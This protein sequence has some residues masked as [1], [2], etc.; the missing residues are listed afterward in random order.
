MCRTRHPECLTPLV[1]LLLVTCVA[2]S[3]M[4]WPA[5]LPDFKI[6]NS[7][8]QSVSSNTIAPGDRWLLIYIRPQCGPCRTVLNTLNQNVLPGVPG[9]SVIILGGASVDETRSMAAAFPDLPF[10]QWYSDPQRSAYL[11]LALQGAPVVVGL[12]QNNIRWTLAG[13]NP[14]TEKFKSTLRSWIQGN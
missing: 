7:A 4:G 14:D 9:K 13:V 5:P 12:Q 1:A 3:S 10:G 11:Q 2:A 8:G 6:I